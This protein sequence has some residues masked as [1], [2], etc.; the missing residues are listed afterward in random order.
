[1]PTAP[2]A[3]WTMVLEKAV[4]SVSF[5]KCV[6][7][8]RIWKKGKGEKKGPVRTRNRGGGLDQL[9]TVQAILKRALMLDELGAVC[10]LGRKDLPKNQAEK[11]VGQDNA[12]Y[13]G[14]V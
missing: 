1:M 4:L 3:R 9:L 11:V 8:A 10:F 12:G 5:S 14:A 7:D 2:I 6:D 13:F